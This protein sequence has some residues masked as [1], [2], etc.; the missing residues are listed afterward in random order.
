MN[1][2]ITLTSQSHTSIACAAGTTALHDACYYGF[3]RCAELLVKH[4]AN[5]NALDKDGQTPLHVTN[6]TG[7]IV[8]IHGSISLILSSSSI[9]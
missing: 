8:I 5:V 7:F 4:K 9:S 1:I 6:S 2:T 3:E